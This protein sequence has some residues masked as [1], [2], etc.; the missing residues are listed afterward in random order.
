ML[1][2]YSDGITEAQNDDGELFDV[3]RLSRLV[4][5]ELAGGRPLAEV[6]AAVFAE[7]ERFSSRHTDDWTLLLVQRN[8][9]LAAA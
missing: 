6:P 1:C 5:R 3:E 4:E 2:L 9:S 7:I 8:A